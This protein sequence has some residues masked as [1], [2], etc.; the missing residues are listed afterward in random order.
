MTMRRFPIPPGVDRQGTKNSIG[1]RW[2]ESNNMRFRDEFP[3]TIGGWVDEGGHTLQGFGRGIHSWLDFEDNQYICVGTSFKFYIL[4]GT[5]RYDI[6]P[7]RL[8]RT[9]G[10]ALTN[11]I[12][13]TAGSSVVTI[14]DASHG[15]RLNDFVV[16]VTVAADVGGITASDFT[17]VDEGFQVLEVIDDDSYKIDVGVVASS[18]VAAG[19]GTVTLD[20]KVTSGA[21][22]DTTGSGFGVGLYGGDTLIPTSYPLNP[23]VNVETITGSPS[24]WFDMTGSGATVALND[25]IYI[26]GLSAITLDGVD[27]DYFNDKWFEVIG[28]FA[29]KALLIGIQPAIAGAVTGGTGGNFFHDDVSIGG[30]VGASRGWGDASSSVALVDALRT[31]TIQ[32]FGEDLMFCNRGGPIYYY[33]VSANV[34][35]GVPATNG[36]AIVIDSTIG[37]STSPVILCDSFIVAKDHGHTIAFGANDIGLGFQNKMLI[38]WGDRHN[39]FAWE[40]TPDNEAGGRVLREGSILY[41]G[42]QTKNEIVVF[43]NTAVYSMRYIGYPETYGFDIITRNAG[44]YSRGSYVAIDNAVF[45]SSMSTMER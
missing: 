21:V 3:E 5:N 9:G 30:V 41:G 37:G 24:L 8:S 39:P 17:S 15:A 11:P 25:Y 44:V 36:P 43:T 4:V 45:F 19:G 13:T 33:D 29:G 38:R 2:Y 42:I 14:T 12:A 16:F 26:T 31:L 35:S 18:P 23:G 10:T 40:P 20:Y 27:L 22:T 28:L 32:N 34:T 6:T 7:V 1:P